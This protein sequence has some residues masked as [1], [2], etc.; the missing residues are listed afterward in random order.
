MEVKFFNK[1]AINFQL[2]TQGLGIS[3][4]YI[5]YWQTFS[6]VSKYMIFTIEAYILIFTFE[7]LTFHRFKQF[8]VRNVV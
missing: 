2:L 1:L 8:F 4:V 3:R 7:V 5:S 6:K